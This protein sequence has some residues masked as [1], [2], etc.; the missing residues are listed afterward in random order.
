M[1]GLFLLTALPLGENKAENDDKDVVPADARTPHAARVG[2]GGST[3]RV[4]YEHNHALFFLPA[5][6][7]CAIKAEGHYTTIFDG[8]AS[9]FCPWSISRLE[10]HLAGLPFIRTHR[11]FLLNLDQVEALQRKKDKAQV[12]LKGSPE[13]VPVSRAHLP[14]LRRALGV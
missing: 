3:L 9:L 4:P 8:S 1:C 7:I 11:S 12:M 5:E 13:T 2:N 10:D 6:R 14:E